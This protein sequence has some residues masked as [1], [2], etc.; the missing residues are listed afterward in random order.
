VPFAHKS[1]LIRWHS[2]YTI[3]PRR[4]CMDERWPRIEVRCV[5]SMT[6]ARPLCIEASPDQQWLTRC[7]TMRLTESMMAPI[8]VFSRCATPLLNGSTLAPHCSSSRCIASL[9]PVPVY[10]RPLALRCTTPLLNGAP[11]ALHCSSSRCFPVMIQLTVHHRSFFVHLCTTT[12]LHTSSMA[13]H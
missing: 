13:P 12:R 4:G 11:M 6:R 3:A 2:L 9:R 1:S 10:H 8:P 7:T 5:T